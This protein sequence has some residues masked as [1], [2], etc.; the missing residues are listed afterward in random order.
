MESWII[1]VGPNPGRGS[2]HA[3]GPQT[4]GPTK[5]VAVADVAT[6]F[7]EAASVLE[8]SSAFE[9]CMMATALQIHADN[10]DG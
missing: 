3:H 1:N 9:Q 4:K 7:R 2:T 8:G 10:L 6:I 5:V